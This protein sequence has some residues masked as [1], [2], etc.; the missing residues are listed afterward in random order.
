MPTYGL[1]ACSS[2]IT[3]TDIGGYKFD[4]YASAKNRSWKM[5]KIKALAIQKVAKTGN[6]GKKKSSGKRYWLCK[7]SQHAEG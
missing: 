4:E 6:I 2:P 7:I 1:I 3:F 5:E